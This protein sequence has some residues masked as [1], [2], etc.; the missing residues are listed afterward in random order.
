[1]GE[2]KEKAIL[3]GPT[4]KLVFELR[5]SLEFANYYWKFIQGYSRKVAPLTDLLKKDQKWTWDVPCQEAFE[6]LKATV[7]SEPVLWLPEFN[8]PFE[9]HTDA[10]DKAIGGCWSRKDTPLHLKEGNF[11]GLN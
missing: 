8:K 3:D 10:S 6:V 7:V 9:V 4:P 11:M 2:R 5:S 1:M